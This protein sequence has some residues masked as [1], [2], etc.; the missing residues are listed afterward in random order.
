MCAD[1]TTNAGE[2]EANATPSEPA[3]RTPRIHD[4]CE[5][6]CVLHDRLYDGIVQGFARKASD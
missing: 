4:E 6:A 1:A 3:Q 5:T 2:Q